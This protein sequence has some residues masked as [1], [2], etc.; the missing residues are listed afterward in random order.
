MSQRLASWALTYRHPL[1]V[2]L[3]RL[4]RREAISATARRSGLRFLCTPGAERM[5]P[6]VF[7]YN[8]YDVPTAPVREGDRVVDVG[9]SHGFVS[10]RYA[11]LG[12]RVLAI[13]PDPDSFARLQAN[14]AANRLVELVEALRCAAG[15]AEGERAL[16]RSREFGGGMSTTVVPSGA[17]QH[18][19]VRDVI[20][21]HT[22]PLA[23]LIT[24][25]TAERIRL[26]KLDC[27]GSE[28]E[29]LGSLPSSLWERID[30]MAIEVH[31]SVYALEDLV[32]Q[33]IE[34]GFQV[35]KVQSLYPN[36]HLV[37][38]DV[39]LD[40]ARRGSAT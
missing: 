18:F 24:D 6:E 37:H 4:L 2:S 8:V 17:A 33:A 10:C 9:A 16:H 38:R 12:A 13:E 20:P 21:V 27:E 5:M 26:L 19:R 32:A 15:A 1:W 35:S 29:I 40:W 31:P 36:L 7:H 22:R 14:V 23:S 30:S 28:F 11:A 34:H 3:Q 39:V 25:W